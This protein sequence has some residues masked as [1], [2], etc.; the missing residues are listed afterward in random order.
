MNIDRTNNHNSLSSLT[1]IFSSRHQCAGVRWWALTRDKKVLVDRPVLHNEPVRKV[2]CIF[3]CPGWLCLCDCKH[4]QWWES[5]PQ[6]SLQK[7]CPFYK[8]FQSVY[9]HTQ[10]LMP[11]YFYSWPKCGRAWVLLCWLLM[12]HGAGRDNVHCIVIDGGVVSAVAG[13]TSRILSVMVTRTSARCW[14]SLGYR[15]RRNFHSSAFGVGQHFAELF[16]AQKMR[17]SR[18]GIRG[19]NM[20]CRWH[21]C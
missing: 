20:P 15:D 19:P 8:V 17:R 16:P 7:Q 14:I 13:F 12:V 10:L 2:F 11:L 18:C 21:R 6:P 9:Q 4:C 5:S 3:R 1:A